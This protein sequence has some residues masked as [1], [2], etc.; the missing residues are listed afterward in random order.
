MITITGGK[1]TTWRRMAKMTV[2]R[3][4]LRDVADA[5]CRTHEIPLGQA[6]DPDALERV[7]GV[8]DEAYPALAGR[9]GY[10]ATEVLRIAGEQ[11]ELA[12]AD[13]RRPARPAR[14][15]RPGRPARA[16]GERRRRAPAPDPARPP[17][18]P[19]PR[20]RAGDARS[21]PRS[22]PSSAGT[23]LE[24]RWSSSRSGP[25]PRPRGSSSGPDGPVGGAIDP[26][27]ARTA[28]GS[29]LPAPTLSPFRARVPLGSPRRT[30]VTWWSGG[31]RPG[32]ASW[33]RSGRRSSGGL[34]SVRGVGAGAI[35]RPA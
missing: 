26:Q 12:G 25:R 34:S 17:R 21:R 31:E 9:Y 11:P 19:G 5:P 10:A 30:P 16:G 27:S 20:R 4:V 32:S 13:R 18:R 3:I 29:L 33:S 2:D 1:L 6:I 14:R 7:A 28:R 35:V 22:R 24:S 15:G 8:P 23:P